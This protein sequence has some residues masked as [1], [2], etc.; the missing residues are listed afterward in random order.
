MGRVDFT[1][2]ERVLLKANEQDTTQ[3][4][5]F[6]QRKKAGVE[7][8]DMEIEMMLEVFAYDQVMIDSCGSKKTYASFPS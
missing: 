3:K 6:D 5:F 8:T 1:L 4:D 7:I 2:N